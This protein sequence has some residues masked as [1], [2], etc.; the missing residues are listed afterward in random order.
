M[1]QSTKEKF[2]VLRESYYLAGRTLM[3]SSQFQA[4]LINLGYAI[5][6]SLKQMLLMAG[7]DPKKLFKHTLEKYYQSL[8]KYWPEFK[9]SASSDFWNTCD[10]GLNSRYPMNLT[11]ELEKD[12]AND[13]LWFIPIDLIHCY[14]D[15]IL[16][17]DE[18]LAETFDHTVCL[19][20]RAEGNLQS[21]Q[22]RTFYHCNDAAF[23]RRSYYQAKLEEGIDG[24][25]KADFDIEEL[26]NFEGLP[27]YRPWPWK[28]NWNPA[29]KYKFPKKENGKITAQAACWKANHGVSNCYANASFTPSK[30]GKVQLSV[31]QKPGKCSD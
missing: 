17:M 2:T 23:D 8:L 13:T 19:G 1:D 20:V 25:K 31:V 30:D 14:D 5:E 12:L 28:K 29:A 10:R 22:G 27:L 9:I 21:N 26:W 24:S 11:R 3:I 16:Q 15:V 18:F 6:L 4:G 7:E